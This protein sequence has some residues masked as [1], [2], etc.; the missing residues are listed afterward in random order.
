MSIPAAITIILVLSIP[1]LVGWLVFALMRK[2]IPNGVAFIAAA[3][4]AGS[5]LM[6]TGAFG[7]NCYASYLTN[8]KAREL[9]SSAELQS[10]RPDIASGVCPIAYTFT[11][12][13]QTEC[14]I[15]V[16]DAGIGCP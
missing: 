8:K 1:L 3:S 4:I 7:N 13:G 9:L 12:R 16:I 10:L 5:V 14:L 2:T 15:F 6:V 11:R